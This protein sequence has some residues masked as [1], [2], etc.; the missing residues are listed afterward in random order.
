MMAENE[1]SLPLGKAESSDESQTPPDPLSTKFAGTSHDSLTP[2]VSCSLPVKNPVEQ[3]DVKIESNINSKKFASKN[4]CVSTRRILG[5]K[6]ISLE[7]Q[8]QVNVLAM[9]EKFALHQKQRKMELEA[10]N[11]A[12][13]LAAIEQEKDLEVKIK[14]L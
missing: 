10:Q 2:L 13:E 11:E 4:S 5:L 14:T 8:A 3:V 9:E 7:E 6:T 12:Q 1:S